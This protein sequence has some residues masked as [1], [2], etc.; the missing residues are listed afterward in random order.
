[1]L[2]VRIYA[3]SELSGLSGWFSTMRSK[4]MGRCCGSRRASRR[5]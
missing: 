4:V 3:R 1:M 5:G 2:K